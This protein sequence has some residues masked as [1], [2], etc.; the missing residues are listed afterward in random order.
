M[1][2]E[3][4]SRLEKLEAES[5]ALSHILTRLLDHLVRNDRH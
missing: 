5:A 1:D 3:E 4:L 2:D